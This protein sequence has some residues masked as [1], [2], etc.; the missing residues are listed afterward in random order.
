MAPRQAHMAP[1]LLLM[2]IAP[3]ERIEAFRTVRTGDPLDPELPASFRSHHAA[4]MEPRYQEAQHAA[5]HMAVSFWR[6]A[7]TL[8]RAVVAIVR[9]ER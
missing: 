4:G 1:Q 3:G 6:D 5:L 2:E 8:T 7:E 9:I